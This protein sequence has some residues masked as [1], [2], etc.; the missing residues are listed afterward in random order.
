M[1]PKGA[2]VKLSSL[3]HKARGHHKAKAEPSIKEQG[4]SK[5]DGSK[6]DLMLN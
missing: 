4:R 3:G 6:A 5:A 2:N 1:G